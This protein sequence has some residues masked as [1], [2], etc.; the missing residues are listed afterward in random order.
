MQKRLISFSDPQYEELRA[1]AEELGISV[2][3]IVRRSVDRYLGRDPD[4]AQQRHS[5]PKQASK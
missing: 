5:E 3:E 2:S 4:Q 1:K